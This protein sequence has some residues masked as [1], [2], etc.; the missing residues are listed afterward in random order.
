MDSYGQISRKK[1]RQTLKGIVTKHEILISVTLQTY[2]IQQV[3]V[4][5]V[6]IFIKHNKDYD[7]IN[8]F[9]NALVWL[10]NSTNSSN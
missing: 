1:L 3:F 8:L 2:N 6:N 10:K 5:F 7:Y 4:I 9:R